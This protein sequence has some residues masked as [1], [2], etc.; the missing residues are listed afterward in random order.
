MTVKHFVEVR[1]DEGYLARLA[2]YRPVTEE[3]RQDSYGSWLICSDPDNCTGWEECRESHMVD[4][5]SASEGPYAADC[6]CGD[7]AD[8]CSVPWCGEEEFVFHGKLH[9]WNYGYGWVTAFDG[10]PA[11][12]GYYETPDGIPMDRPGVYEVEID[13]GGDEW[14]FT[15]L[16]DEDGTGPSPHAH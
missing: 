8:E 9:E 5:V 14:Y 10:C 16:R 2:K 1:I 7:G 3:D 15:L 6:E 12:S 13:W 11:Q 4:G